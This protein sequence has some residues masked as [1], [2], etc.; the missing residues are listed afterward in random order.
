MV[1]FTPG[2]G[3]ERPVLK[4]LITAARL[5]VISEAPATATWVFVAGAFCILQRPAR[6]PK[7][8]AA[9]S[10]PCQVARALQILLADCAGCLPHLPPRRVVPDTG[11]T[12]HC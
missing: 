2:T 4:F 1:P 3:V 9:G 7:D 12:E 10:S 5:H 8:A 11:L 6:A